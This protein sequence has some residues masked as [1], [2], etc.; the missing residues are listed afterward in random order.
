M[1]QHRQAVT[2]R[3]ARVRVAPR[4]RSTS[5]TALVVSPRSLASSTAFSASRQS[6]RSDVTS[7]IPSRR[8]HRDDTDDPDT[9][10]DRPAVRRR[11]GDT[12]TT[13]NDHS[14]H[15]Q[16]IYVQNVQNNYP[17]ATPE[18]EARADNTVGIVSMILLAGWTLGRI[19][20]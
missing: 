17:V 11:Q 5:S 6:T 3:F 1:R 10:S 13:I 7:A 8:R 9:D 15:R 12:V 4:Q 20:R 14:D 2:S 16:T 18:V 19:C